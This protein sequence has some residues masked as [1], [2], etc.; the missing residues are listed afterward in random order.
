ML[1]Q[2]PEQVLSQLLCESFA[3]VKKLI[4]KANHLGDTT[5]HF[6]AMHGRTQIIHLLREANEK[7]K[8][9]MNKAN[10]KGV[11]PLMTAASKMTLPL[12]KRL[13]KLAH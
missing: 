5:L 4:N 10:R 11:T 7:V 3:S 9:K 12:L 2:K 6:A 1:I 8:V 13:L